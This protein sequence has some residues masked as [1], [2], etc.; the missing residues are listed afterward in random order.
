MPGSHSFQV[1]ATIAEGQVTVNNWKFFYFYCNGLRQLL[2]AADSQLVWTSLNGGD[3]V[4][5]RVISDYKVVY[6]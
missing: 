5:K 2:V 1:A 3:K 4:S 6:G